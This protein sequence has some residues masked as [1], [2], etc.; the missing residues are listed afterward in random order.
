MLYIMDIYAASEDP[1]S[2]VSSESL[3]K[4][5]IEKGG[6]NV[7]HLNGDDMV[8]TVLGELKENFGL[9]ERRLLRSFGERFDCPN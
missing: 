6:K 3:S 8:S 5:V 9:L 2:G 4:A 7:R 1:I